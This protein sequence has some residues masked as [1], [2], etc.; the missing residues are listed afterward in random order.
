MTVMNTAVSG[1]LGQNNWLSTIAQ[2]VANAATTGYKDAETQFA[3]LVDNAGAAGAVAGMGVSTSSLTLAALQGSI[4]G[5]AV[6]T[7]LAIQGAGFFV[8]SN[9]SDQTYLTRAGS[10]VPDASGNLV[11]AAGY[12]LMGEPIRNGASPTGAGSLAALQT[13]NVDQAPTYVAPTTAGALAVNLPSTASIV[14]AAS[15]PAGGGS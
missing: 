15:T 5:T 9:G 6:P 12:S 14:A 4:S 2:N 1:M 7:N 11:N 10:F 3:S 8:V 13:V